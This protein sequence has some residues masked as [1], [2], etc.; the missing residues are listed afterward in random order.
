MSKIF[1]FSFLISVEQENDLLV[2]GDCQTNFPLKDIQKFIKHKVL[3]CN[4]ENI[5]VLDS[6]AE[7]DDDDSESETIS[8]IGSKQPSISAPIAR[9]ESQDTKHSPRPSEPMKE[10]NRSLDTNSNKHK[11]DENGNDDRHSLPLKPHKL[12]VDAESNTTHSGK[13]LR[14]LILA[15]FLMFSVKLVFSVCVC[16]V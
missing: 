15:S 1:F 5:S 9:K 10:L 3:R 8:Q 7:Y 16:E 13:S 12:V 14:F 11:E 4:K 6:E 2:C